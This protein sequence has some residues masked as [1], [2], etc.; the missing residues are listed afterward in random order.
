MTPGESL[1]KLA[2]RPQSEFTFYM[3]PRLAQKH[4]VW[5]VDGQ[6][7][8]MPKGLIAAGLKAIMK[9]REVNEPPVEGDKQS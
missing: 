9:S 7:T 6:A 8:L 1:R 2:G 3:S 5:I 4:E